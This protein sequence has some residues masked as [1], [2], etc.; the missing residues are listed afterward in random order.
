MESLLNALSIAVKVEPATD[1]KRA[2]FDGLFQSNVE[3][4]GD[5]RYDAL[6][7]GAKAAI[8]KRDAK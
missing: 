7:A 3:R 8:Q 4:T 6:P 2:L 1:V 5:G